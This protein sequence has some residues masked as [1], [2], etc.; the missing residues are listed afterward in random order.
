MKQGRK[1]KKK[2]QHDT[3]GIQ[4]IRWTMADLRISFTD[5]VR[6]AYVLYNQS[7]SSYS[8]EDYDN[9]V[10]VVPAAA[11]RPHT[12]KIRWYVVYM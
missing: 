7:F 4:F 12:S 5:T 10:G 1:K 9:W 2:I 6:E 3:L 11:L 8:E